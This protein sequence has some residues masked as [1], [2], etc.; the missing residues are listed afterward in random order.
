M[1]KVSAVIFDFG[2][3]L[4]TFDKEKAYEYFAEWSEYPIQHFRD[5]IGNIEQAYESGKVDDEFF[6]AYVRVLLPQH[7]VTDA[8][9]RRIWGNIFTPVPAIVPI[10]ESLIDRNIPIAVLSNTNGIHF[11]FMRDLPIIRRL[12]RY[13]APFVLSY[14]LKAFKPDV[15]MYETALR[16]LELSD[17]SHAL[18]LD[19]LPAN[20]EG[21]RA[22][23]MHAEV[24]D[25]NMPFCAA[26]LKRILSTYGIDIQ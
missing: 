23:G 17:P 25:C 9:I 1:D 3:V 7:M 11:P 5:E 15:R 18:F 12:R 20:V 13:G 16:K 4:A 8:D 19:D 10:V 22:Y 21:A 24:F 6:I 14:E 2:N 26:G